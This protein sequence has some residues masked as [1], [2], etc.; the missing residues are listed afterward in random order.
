M[1]IR[2]ASYV[3]LLALIAA[4]GCRG[5]SEPTASEATAE[6]HT[7][8]NVEA[9]TRFVGDEACFDCHE[10]QYDGYR[11]HGMAR[12]YYPLTD[13]NRVEPV[14][15]VDIRDRRSG[16][17]YR[18][19]ET[20]AGLFQEE[21]WIG[22][23]GR[24]SVGL[25]RRIDYVV[26]SGNAARTYLTEENGRLYQLPL[27]WYTQRQRWDFSPGYEVVNHRFDRLV[28]D[29][30][31]ACHNS[32]P[33]SVPYVEGKYVNV[34]NGIGC[35][36]CHGP[37]DL[38]LTERLQVPEP[39]GDWD[40]SIV[41]PAH[42]SFERRLDVCQQCHLHTAVSLLRDGK[43]P[44][45]FRPSHRLEDFQALFGESGGSERADSEID[46]ISHADR[47]RQSECF[48]ATASDSAPLECTTCH[49]PHEGFRQ[50]GPDYF[51]AACLECHDLSA[52]VA[53]MA[54]SD[55]ASH[56]QVGQPCFTCHMPRV[57]AGD[58]PH[59]SF[60]D[61]L[62]RVVERDTLPPPAQSTHQPVD[63]EPYF[64][65]D[66]T[67]R[68]GEV[69]RSMARIVYGRQTGN[70][71]LIRDGTNRLDELSRQDS[72]H[73]EAQFLL[74]LGWQFLG[75]SD[76]A[77]RALERSVRIDPDNPE[78]LNALAQSIEHA[79]GSPLTVGRLYRRA[80]AIQP[81]EADIR[82]NYGRFL[83]SQGRLDDAVEQ[84]RQAISESPW[85]GVAYYNLGTALAA[86]GDLDKAINAL[87]EAIR[88]NPLYTDA[89]G[90]LAAIHAQ[91]GQEA[92]AERLF[93]RAAVADPEDPVALGN[94]GAFRLNQGRYDEATVL[95]G[96]AV[97][98]DSTFVDALANLALAHFREDRFELARRYAGKAIELAPDHALARQVIVATE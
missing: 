88:L 72:L 54:D 64:E 97:R 75:E 57:E 17:S 24:K 13:A 94:L 91:T 77:Q 5:G 22:Q 86:S 47:M 53:G 21:F 74:G 67:S 92:E 59:S 45:G 20:D 10:D 18:V 68:D 90:N 98:A 46:V 37:G 28:P 6:Q 25:R 23:D 9:E 71:E 81:A 58:A 31:M 40:D 85:L 12:S 19:V 16:L 95:L 55:A 1:Q 30:C 29:R 48:L 4:T 50:A 93:E 38:H 87:E 3:T 39:D 36:R 11:E 78:R 14:T 63:L 2:R 42:L 44:F 8:R 15:T 73:G 89:L 51:N 32:Y 80:L 65:R 41:N 96:R 62:I 61:H 79:G 60:T 84:Y 56:H 43:S 33:V 7:F 83:Q 35:E 27:T 34:P 66:R 26:G 49:N 52:L 76:R 82:V 70:R 69:Y